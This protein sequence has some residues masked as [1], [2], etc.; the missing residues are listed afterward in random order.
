MASFDFTVDTSEMADSLRDVSNHVN[1]VTTAVVAMQA[2]VIYAEK[3]AAERI[4]KNVD[5]GFY[6]LIRSQISQKIAALRSKVDSRMLEMR[7]QSVSLA[8]VRTR[9]E[10][11]FAMIAARYTKLF[12][13]LD[14]SLR[15]RVYELD[16]AA[17][18]LQSKDLGRIVS[19]A[20]GMQASVPMHQM[21]TISTR[22]G[23]TTARVKANTERAI[24][25]M[26]RFVHDATRQRLLVSRMLGSEDA[27]E[28]RVC[29][30]PVL[31]FNMDSLRTEQSQWGYHVPTPPD[32]AIAAKVGREVSNAIYGDFST[33]PWIDSRSSQRE[34]VSI[35][36]NR[37]VDASTLPERVRVQMRKLHAESY[38]QQLRE[39]R[40]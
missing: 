18:M 3:A 13:S 21:E 39:A 14:A 23:I 17:V 20:E 4:C 2:A 10:R 7:Q 5:L 1:G 15:T 6:S 19:R 30:L 33:R 36:F 12:Q 22:Q 8:G 40:S 32:A 38:W 35:H 25:A 28:N 27:T 34:R 31:V 24:N 37:K 29:T 16:H 26:H 11:D 9:M